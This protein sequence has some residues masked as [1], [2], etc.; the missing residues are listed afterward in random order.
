[1]ACRRHL[2][3]EKITAQRIE[4]VELSRQLQKPLALADAGIK[5]VHFIRRHPALLAGSVTILLAL[6][7]GD[8][9][10]VLQQGWRL[11]S[12]YPATAYLSQYLS[13]QRHNSKGS[14]PE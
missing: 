7:R 12:L 2:L 4:I 6:H 11:L 5:V 8:L 14:I 1:M 9:R 3:L 10:H 13:C